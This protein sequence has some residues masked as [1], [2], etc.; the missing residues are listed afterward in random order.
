MHVKR[1]SLGMVTAVALAVLTLAACG[2]KPQQPQGMV[3]EV[4]VVT[5]QPQN[6][7]LTT[8]L[9]GRTSPYR[10][11]DVR[12]RVDGIVLKRDFT[13][14]G[15]VKAGQRLY[16]IDP[17]TYQAAYENA[18]AT[19]AKAVANQASTKLLADRYKSLVA[20]EAVSKQDYDNAVAAALQADADV[21]AGKAAVDTA[22]INLGYTDVPAPITGRT[23]L[24]QVTEGAYVQSGA[25][26]LMT[27]VQQ[28]DPMYVDVTQ[29][30]TDG[31]RLRRA[32]ADGKL[33]SAGPNAAKVELTLED[34]SKYPLDGKLQFS[35][36]TVD[37]TTGSVTVRAIF[38]N[39]NRELLPGMFVHAKLA[40]GVKEGGLLVPQQG[41]TRD[42]KGQPT[43][44]VVNKEGKAEL[45]QL[46]TDRAI[47]DKWLVTSGLSAGE[48]VIVSGLQK[49]RPGAPVKAV[50]AQ[51][52]GAAPAPAGASAPAAADPATQASAASAAKAQ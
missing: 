47:G 27:T 49:A 46:V 26:T 50:P 31:L 1:S 23:G 6:V 37:Q 30:A 34:G 52:P 21:A 20:V 41:V 11:A 8:D 10:V 5:L 25:A 2:K 29:S 9:P 17:A 36:I 32:L 4:G 15:E 44:L 28:I 12:A 48:Q 38:P 16:K 40:E 24:S 39:P 3:P 42:Q 33:Q 19:L 35:D 13:E 14:G 22:R 18:K 51:L 43:A 7:T 45:R